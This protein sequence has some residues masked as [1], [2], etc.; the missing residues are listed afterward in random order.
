[1]PT[2]AT[3]YMASEVPVLVFA[4]AGNAVTEYAREK[5]WGYVVDKEDKNLL[6]K[7]IVEIL[8][9]Q[10]LRNRIIKNARNT[11]L[12]KHDAD[13]VREQ[14]RRVL[15]ISKALESESGKRISGKNSIIKKTRV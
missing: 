10:G 2:K 14:F 12:V 8:T 5:D 1:M 6:Q 9:N 13:N 4:P 3:E 7:G 11:I 15:T